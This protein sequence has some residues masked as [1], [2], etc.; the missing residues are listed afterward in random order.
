MEDPERLLSDPVFQ[1]RVADIT[2]VR[3]RLLK[4]LRGDSGVGLE[5]IEEPVVLGEI[6]RGDEKV[7]LA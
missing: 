3:D 4:E 2:D 6:V 5:R 1:E 7:V